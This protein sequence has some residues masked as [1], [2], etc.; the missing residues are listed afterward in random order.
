[1]TRRTPIHDSPEAHQ[2]VERLLKRYGLDNDPR[3]RDPKH[4]E[5]E[6]TW[7][8]RHHHQNIRLGFLLAA[9]RRINQAT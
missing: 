1:M 3:W 4:I 5:H 8:K 6:L 7:G 9:L 2:A